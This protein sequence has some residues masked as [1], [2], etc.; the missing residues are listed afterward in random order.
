MEWK[1]SKSKGIGKG[2]IYL[3]TG[4]DKDSRIDEGKESKRGGGNE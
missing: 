3:I 4:R 2:G 1:P